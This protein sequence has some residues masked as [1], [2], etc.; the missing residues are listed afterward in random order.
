MS[1]A[2]REQRLIAQSTSQIHTR[3][4]PSAQPETSLQTAHSTDSMGWL[5]VGELSPDCVLPSLPGEAA[6]SAGAWK[7]MKKLEDH[8]VRASQDIRRG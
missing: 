1:T 7:T 5:L 4:S 8:K 6:G 2:L 3:A